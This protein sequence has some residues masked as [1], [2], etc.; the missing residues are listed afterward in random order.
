MSC[1]VNEPNLP[2][3]CAAV[4]YGQKYGKDLAKSLE[5]LHIENIL[6]PDN[7]NID[8]RLAGHADLS[9]LHTGGERLYL[10]PYLKEHS[11]A[12]EL[13][14]RGALLHFSELQ[15]DRD[16]PAD[17][18][19]NVCIMGK[20][21]ICNPKTA[22]ARI[23]EHLTKLGDRTCIPVRQGYSRCAVCTV[24]A[25]SI[26]T[27][28]RGIATSAEENGLHVLLIRPGYIRLD[29]FL[30]GFIGG[31]SFK[32][33]H[34]KLAF[35]GNLDAHPDREKILGFL[36]ERGIQAVFLTREPAFDIGSAIPIFEN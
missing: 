24:D 36:A 8:P 15:Q 18:Q 16:Y 9:L 21:V 3:D 23:V 13:R 27:A 17:A 20:H 19:L 29:G 32:L 34:D 22:A 26:I 5:S 30:Y 7:P 14:T 28:D 25:D 31:A 11:F 1:F 4:I 33:A 2:I 35:T 10:A 12:E 6:L